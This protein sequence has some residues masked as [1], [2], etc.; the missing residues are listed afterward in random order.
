[1]PR[2]S[3]SDDRIRGNICPRCGRP[4]P[5]AGLCG[6]CRAGDLP[7]FSCDHR[8]TITFCPVCGAR[9]E[10]GVW[11]DSPAPRDDVAYEAAKRAV[12]IIPEVSDRSL[13]L[14]ITELSVNRSLAVCNVKGVLFGEPVEGSCQI[15]ILWRKEQCDRCNRMSG[16]YYEG[17][18]QVRALGRKPRPAEIRT[19]TQIARE[20]EEE[21]LASGERLSFISEME[22]TRDG[23]DIT[24]GSQRIGKEIASAIVQRLGGRV[25][26]HPKLVGEKAGKRLFRITYSV[27]LSAFMRGDIILV[28]GRYGE[29]LSGDGRELRYRD[30][31]NKTTRTTREQRV[32]RVIGNV[33]DAA[34]YQ[35]TFRHGD[36][37]G[38]LD[39]AT[40]ECSEHFL[41]PGI[42][43]EIGVKVR[44]VQDQDRIILLGTV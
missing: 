34:L 17:I 43:V 18:V 20:V 11:T 35:V 4:T 10:V 12:H 2:S 40:G 32:E 41:P 37:I 23:L 42:E 19:A 36:T 3:G 39:P 5:D 38:L 26:T 22:E 14:V 16:S 6:A 44:V 13:D 15:E 27:R 31:D 29:V 25:T 24:V 21:C 30:L 8:V 7:W 28:R 1:M 33:R 9:R